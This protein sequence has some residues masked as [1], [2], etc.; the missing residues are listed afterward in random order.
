MD[1]DFV[2]ANFEKISIDNEYG[3]IDIGIDPNASYNIKGYAKYADIDYPHDGRVSR[4]KESTSLQI[5]GL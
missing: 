4:I 2:S 5:E 3:N 1:V